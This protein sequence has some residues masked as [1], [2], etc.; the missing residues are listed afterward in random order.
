M[1]GSKLVKVLGL[2][3]L[4]GGLTLGSVALARGPG[5]MH[6]GP[7]G[8]MAK[9]IEKLDLDPEQQALAKEL[10]AGMEDEREAIQAQHEEAFE[11]LVSEL[12]KESPDAEVLHDLVDEGTA[13]MAERM[14]A[15]L[16]SMLELQAT[17]TEEQ[18]ATL[19]E[20]MEAG[21]E[22]RDAR[23]EEMQERRSEGGERG[24]R[25]PR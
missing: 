6:G 22:M 8:H 3:T 1:R 7:G 2:T 17:F 10:K 21:K 9:V 25:G 19:V 13:L 16:D 5:G 11:V 20:E 18:R 12:G 4:I 24:K 15:G 23:R 14:H